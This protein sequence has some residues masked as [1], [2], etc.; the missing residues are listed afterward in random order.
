MDVGD[1]ADIVLDDVGWKRKA[2]MTICRYGHGEQRKNILVNS[3][4]ISFGDTV[5]V[6]LLSIVE[7]VALHIGVCVSHVGCLTLDETFIVG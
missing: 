7:Y 5:V 4:M 1:T 6:L 3:L 2:R